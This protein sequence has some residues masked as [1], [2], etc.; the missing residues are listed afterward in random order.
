MEGMNQKVVRVCVFECGHYNSGWIMAKSF[1]G[2]LR[3]IKCVCVWVWVQLQWGGG[4]VSYT[5]A[6]VTAF[7]GENWL[8]DSNIPVISPVCS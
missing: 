1:C 4:A 2:L 7:E 8:P 3:V 6:A 5:N